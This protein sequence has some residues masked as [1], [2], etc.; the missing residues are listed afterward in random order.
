M[1]Y[2]NVHISII[3]HNSENVETQMSMKW[4][5]NKENVAYSYHGKLF[6]NT[7]KWTSIITMAIIKKKKP[8]EN[9]K[10]WQVCEETRTLM[11][12]CGKWHGGFSKN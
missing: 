4:C 5:V 12:C 9:K 2:M 11:Q 10:Y 1:S 8:T 3:I 6:I 7:K